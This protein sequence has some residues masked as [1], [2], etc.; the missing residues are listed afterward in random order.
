LVITT[1]VSSPMLGRIAA[2]LGARYE[3]TLTGF[4]WIENRALEV[5][6]ETGA[7]LV[8]G[9]EEALG[10]SVGTLARDKD[11]IGAAMAFA[12]LAATEKSRGSSV[13]ERLG[14]IY[15]EFGLVV[16]QQ[17][18][19][20]RAGAEGKARI[21]REMSR[22][23]AAPPRAIAGIAVRML[24]DYQAR[25]A[26]ELSTG[27]VTSLTLPASDVLSFELETGAR[28][29]MRPSGTE[30]KIKYYVDWVESLAADES[31]AAGEARAK[32]NCAALTRA[33]AAFAES[34]G[35]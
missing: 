23:R 22:V 8:L 11:G 12:D 24:R 28:I 35:A 6:S 26:T 7:R 27:D 16:S 3:E 13:I 30:P 25:T 9:Y 5:E 18:N 10:Y 19:V 31:L 15:R 29:T 33:F 34:A 20:T 4:K 17:H 21:A 14:R 1:I 2:R 32:E